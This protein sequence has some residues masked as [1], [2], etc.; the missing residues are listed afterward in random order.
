[1]PRWG[2][3]GKPARKSSGLSLRKSSNSRNGSNS[4][5]F[6]KPNARRSLTPAPS[7]V[8][9]AST[10]LLI[11][12][13][14]T[15]SPSTS[16]ALPTLPRRAR[17]HDARPLHVVHPR[18][19]PLQVPVALGL[20]PPLIRPPPSRCAFAVP[21]IQA[22]HDVHPLDDLCEGRE[23]H[24]VEPVVTPEVDEYLRRTCAGACRRER[25]EA[26][27]V[28]AADG[29]VGNALIAP[30]RRDRRVAVNTELHHEP[31]NHP[32]EAYAIEVA[33]AH[34]VVETIRAERGPAAV[35]GDHEVARARLEP[36]AEAVGRLRREA[37]AGG[38]MEI[39]R[40]G[41]AR[42]L[43]TAAGGEE[44]RQYEQRTGG[45]RHGVSVSGR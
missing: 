33:G 14:D 26:A 19:R 44:Q 16:M 3:Q 41:G 12:R 37:R 31:R 21:G 25:H 22:V 40:R 34:E 18:E 1:M 28:G 9:L 7:M 8:G 35:H 24:R 30:R 36:G 43:A 2:C 13:I 32:K 42:S 38:I 10:M 27:Q 4:W 20:N 11:G 45:R 29:V 6:P 5:V 17:F 23:P 39:G 15:W